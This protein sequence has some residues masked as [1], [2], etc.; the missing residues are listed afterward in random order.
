MLRG[1]VALLAVLAASGAGLRS[2]DPTANDAVWRISQRCPVNTLFVVLRLYGKDISYQEI[3]EQLPVD[4]EGTSLVDMRNFAARHGL[5]GRVRKLTPEQ[6]AHVRFP[7][8]AHLEDELATSG[9]FVV[10][11][12]VGT[13]DD[14]FQMVECID[15]TTGMTAPMDM[16]TFRKRWTGFVLSFDPEPERMRWLLPTAMASLGGLLVGLTLIRIRLNRSGTA[17]R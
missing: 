5:A 12:E 14:G 6:L 9:H 3:L 17:R 8:I 7:I 11:L 2:E 4:R 13:N 10:L 1:A 16:T 15:G